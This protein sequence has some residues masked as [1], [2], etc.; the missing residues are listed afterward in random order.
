LGAAIATKL[1]AIVLVPVFFART[2]SAALVA[3]CVVVVAI[4]FALFGADAAGFLSYH[5]ERGEQVESV[6]AGVVALLHVAGALHASVAVDH[7]AFSISFP[8]D[9]AVLAAQP[10]AMVVVVAAA[11]A[12]GA[13]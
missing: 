9:G 3:V 4:P 12:L 10:F 8:H 2:K 7:A 6:V 13:R 1:Y 5:A 11:V